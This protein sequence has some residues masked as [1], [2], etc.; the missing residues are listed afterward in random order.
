MFSMLAI[1]SLNTLYMTLVSTLFA[2]IFGLPLGIAL[3]VTGKNGIRPNAVVNVILGTLINIFRAVPFLIL[4]IA[5]S[6]FTQFVTGTTIGIAATIVPLVVSATPFIAR[7]V[8]GSV[9]E[10]DSGVIEA[11]QSMGASDW[12][13]VRKVMLTEAK[14]AILVGSVVALV[15]ILGYSAMAGIVGG[16]GLGAVAINYGLYKF[17]AEVQW[18]TI[19]VIVILVQILQELGMWISRRTDNRI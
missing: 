2:Y 14:P 5:I 10:I 7:L 11:A 18:I 19:A 4:L 1:Q 15:T 8:E 9:L 6:P 12:Q 16:A 17:N 3:V 13:I